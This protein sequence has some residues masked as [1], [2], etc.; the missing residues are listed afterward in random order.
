[1]TD[2][3]HE[4]ISARLADVGQRYTPGRRV[5]V[6]RLAAAAQPITIPELLDTPPRLP[7]SSAY[8]NLEDRKS[9]V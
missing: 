8:R 4:T 7:Q 3:L 6:D 5:L 1:M 2:D 9:V